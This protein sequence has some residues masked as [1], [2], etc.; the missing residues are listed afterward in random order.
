MT[1]HFANICPKRKKDK[2]EGSKEDRPGMGTPYKRSRNN[3][4]RNA[5]QDRSQQKHRTNIT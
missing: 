4:S 5:S 2:W 3:S 1:D